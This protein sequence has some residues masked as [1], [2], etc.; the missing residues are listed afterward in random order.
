MP[1]RSLGF[2][3]EADNR[4]AGVTAF[5]GLP[6]VLDLMA[7][8]GLGEEIDE[9]VQLR[10]T[11]GWCDLQH[12]VTVVLLNLVGGDFITDV[13]YLESDPGLS[14][15][16]EHVES[17]GVRAEMADRLQGRFRRGKQRS[18]P[19]PT[20]LRGWLNDF[21]C[22][23]PTEG[24]RGSEG[25]FLPH[26]SDAL[27]GL[28]ELVA[29]IAGFEQLWPADH[30]TATLDLDATLIPTKNRQ[31]KFCYK[32]F[33]AYQ[34][35]NVYWAEK[36]Q[37]LYSEFRNGNCPASWR[38]LEV[39]QAGLDRL[40]ERVEQVRFR[41]D[42]A[43]YQT[44][45]LRYLADGQHPRFGA[46]EFSIG[47]P[48]SDGFR[49][50]V[51]EVDAEQWSELDGGRQVAEVNFVPDWMGHSKNGPTYRYLAV[52]CPLDEVDAELEEAQQTLPFPVAQMD[53]GGFCKLFGLV[54]NRHDLDAESLVGWHYGRCGDAEKAHAAIKGQLAGGTMPSSKHLQANAAWWQLALL[55]F[56][57]ARLLA[58][59]VLP[60]ER[61]T[62]MMMKTFRLHYVGLAGRVVNHARKL[63]VRIRPN[64]PNLE[65]ILEAHS[66]LH[67]LRRGPPTPWLKGA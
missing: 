46:I 11:Q 19:S 30:T 33:R 4:D 21:V 8:A 20:A 29:H 18:F 17:H 2:Q 53:G 12:I 51:A 49:Q 61:P 63:R 3:F 36:G 60:D 44:R 6:L 28:R 58:R 45:L 62:G 38:N 24:W 25:A 7:T 52:R 10:P 34:P 65:S 1:H 16:V 9:H 57:L 26:P 64:H 50:A 5:G 22:D 43:S 23:D 42:T 27:K 40:P 35:L 39:L 47:V 37:M 41:A 48:I 13:D 67:I 59:D 31:A 55:A 66:R 15:I 56:N 14:T 32:G 54:S